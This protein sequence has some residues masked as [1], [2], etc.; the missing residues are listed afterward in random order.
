MLLALISGHPSC[1]EMESL[2]IPVDCGS[3]YT[4]ET[5]QSSQ[6]AMGTWTRVSPQ[7]IYMPSF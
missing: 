4:A 7:Y 1:T 5:W 2:K 3:V 6:R